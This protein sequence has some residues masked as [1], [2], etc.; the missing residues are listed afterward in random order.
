M[1]ILVP[2]TE[3][4]VGIG[5]DPRFSPRAHQQAITTSPSNNTYEADAFSPKVDMGGLQDRYVYNEGNIKWIL[6]QYIAVYLAVI[7]LICTIHAYL[8]SGHLRSLLCQSTVEQLF[9]K[10]LL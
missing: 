5:V 10:P 8:A 9:K 1:K 3:P 6:T 4:F 7:T 2:T